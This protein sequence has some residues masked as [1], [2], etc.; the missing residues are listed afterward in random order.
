MASVSWEF[1]GCLGVA[2]GVPFALFLSLCM[3][4]AQLVVVTL[5]AATALLVALVATGLVWYILTPLRDPL[6][7][8]PLLV[9]VI[10]VV[11]YYFFR[12]YCRVERQ[13]GAVATNAV[14]YPLS[15]FYS[16][17]AAGVGFGAAY[18]LTMYGGV[19]AEAT[20]PGV[21]FSAACPYM[22][23]FVFSAWHACC[24]NI[25]HVALSVVSFDAWQ[26]RYWPKLAML[27]SLHFLA[28]CSTLLL[29]VPH[30]CAMALMLSGVVTIVSIIYA[31]YVTGGRAYRAS[32]SRS[33]SE[34][35]L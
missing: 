28:A 32:K 21:V 11:R 7:F 26:R 27:W 24:L 1:F 9:I 20:G 4:Q 19:F 15:D 8:L 25:T 22:S 12:A 31:I 18:T 29:E 6:L 30:G 35:R 34:R 10:E 17:L 14:S 23:T 5:A 16:S 2:Y 3:R 33:A 13:F